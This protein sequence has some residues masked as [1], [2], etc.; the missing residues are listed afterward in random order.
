MSEK[1]LDFRKEKQA[2]SIC[3]LLSKM[4]L[5]KGI[6]FEK[7][8]RSSLYLDFEEKVWEYGHQSVGNDVKKA[9]FCP[10]DYFEV[11]KLPFEK[12]F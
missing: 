4:N 6:F 1:V 12:S 9:F 5:L 8:S 10:Q 2:E 7:S 11:E 3:I